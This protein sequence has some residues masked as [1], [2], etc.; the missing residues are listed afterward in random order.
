MTRLTFRQVAKYGHMTK[1]RLALVKGPYRWALREDYNKEISPR[2][3]NLR[4]AYWWVQGYLIKQ[5][6]VR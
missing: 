4:A 1:P 2:F 5:Y 6:E 3:E